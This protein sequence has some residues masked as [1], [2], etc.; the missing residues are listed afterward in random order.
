MKLTS[1]GQLTI[2][3]KLRTKF[4]LSVNSEIEVIEDGNTLRIIKKCGESTPVDR[5]YGIL[6]K[7]G[8]TDSYI[9]K[10][11]GR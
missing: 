1:K 2:P 3:K 9:E 11:R 10:M 5:V 6:K 7:R 8:S 4:G